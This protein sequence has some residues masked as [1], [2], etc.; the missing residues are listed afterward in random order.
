MRA[1]ICALRAR[2]HDTHGPVSHHRAP[3]RLTRPQS[4]MPPLD[5]SATTEPLGAPGSAV[6][7][8]QPAESSAALGAVSS[9]DAV[10]AADL[11]DGTRAVSRAN[12]VLL[13]HGASAARRPSQSTPPDDEA[14]EEHTPVSRELSASSGDDEY[15]H[16]ETEDAVDDGLPPASCATH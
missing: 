4:E 14:A 10:P 1:C 8:H 2:G 9:S 3:R 11:E 13:M 15:V 6:D 12:A 5:A 7:E 16:I